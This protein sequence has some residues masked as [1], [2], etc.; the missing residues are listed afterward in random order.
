[1]SIIFVTSSDFGQANVILAV[2]EQLLQHK[3]SSFS[4]HIASTASL[5][6]RLAQLGP[7]PNAHFHSIPGDSMFGSYVKAGHQIDGL[8]H[9]P[10]VRGAISSF[11]NVPKMMEHW[12][13]GQYLRSYNVCKEIIQQLLPAVV[14]VDPICAPEIDACRVLGQKLIVLSPMGLKDLLVPVQP[15]GGMLWNY[16]A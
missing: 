8:L 6:S 10:G 11:T 3:E 4:V 5:A 7:K 12:K 14:V 16:P 2:A 13:N 9:R 1:M 15:W